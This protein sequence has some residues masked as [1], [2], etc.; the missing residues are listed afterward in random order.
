[1]PSAHEYFSAQFQKWE[2]RGRG[3]QLFQQ[4]VSP[5][6]PFVP[7]TRRAMTDQ[8]VV[9]DGCRPSF[10]GSLFQRLAQK[11]VPVVEPEPEEEPEPTPLIRDS[12]VEFQ[13]SLPVD[14]DT[15]KESYESLFRNLAL[16]R[17]PMAFELMGI[18]QR[19]VAQF[20][21]CREDAP[22][23][24]KQLAAHFPEV[25]CREQADTLETAWTD[26]NGDEAL[27][28]DF[29]LEREFMFPLASG[30]LDP[31]IGV[32]GTLAELQPGELAVFQVIFQAAREDWPENIIRSV[33]HADGK[34][35][36]VNEPDLASAAAKKVDNRSS[37]C[38]P[39]AAQ[40]PMHH[41]HTL[42]KSVVSALLPTLLL[43]LLPGY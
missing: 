25:Q 20:A 29:G 36:F 7:F 41:V 32:V 38:C 30:K 9:D 17:E 23:V 14:F 3:W 18:H 26:S 37:D 19:V 1:M 42:P 21:A 13:V 43:R 8:P 6:P 15:G 31:F 4:P 35:F 27:A 16:C 33:T 40:H 39:S 11:P 24:R 5:E 22:Q 2:Q 12:L 34:P 28:V 10:L